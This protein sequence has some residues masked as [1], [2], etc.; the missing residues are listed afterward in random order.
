[1]SQPVRVLLAGFAGF[2]SQDHQTAMYLPALA[3]HAGFEIVAAVPFAAAHDVDRAA[4]AAAHLGVPLVGSAAEALTRSDVDAV[5]V[6]AT[7]GERVAAVTAAL[8]AGKHVLADKPLALTAAEVRQI[9][10]ARVASGRVVCVAHHQRFQPMLLAAAPEL[11]NGRVGL[12]WNVHV[13]FLVAGGDRC[14]DGEL[15]NFGVYPLDVLLALTGQPVHRVY[16]RA[17][18]GES[19]VML[20]LDHAN[21]LTSTIVA[22]RTGSRLGVPAGG[23]ALHRYR[24]SGS[25]GTAWIDATKPA[26][27][28]TTSSTV[29]QYTVDPGTV[30]RLLDDFR[31][32]IA[33]DRPATVS[34]VEALW[35][36]GILDA[37]R[38]SLTSG[39]PEDVTAQQTDSDGT[40]G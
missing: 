17:V 9:E 2:G 34:I 27:T 14:P 1:M 35:V 12:P 19:L 31:G 29:E 13:D 16:A 7:P 32:A 11:A 4:K 24:V 3:A 6:C 23:L 18:A 20:A 26:V 8:R 37:A 30:A 21:G 15:L 36:A 10:K 28:V 38:R 40:D 25:H 33:D 5:S 22:G 39:R